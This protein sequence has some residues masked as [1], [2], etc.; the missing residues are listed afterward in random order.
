VLAT[1]DRAVPSA[2]AA[3]TR[4]RKSCEYAFMPRA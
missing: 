4:S 3:T 2:T 1:A